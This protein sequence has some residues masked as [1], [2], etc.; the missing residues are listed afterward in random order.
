MSG[1]FR[2]CSDD[3]QR[4][5]KHFVILLSGYV[6]RNIKRS[7]DFSLVYWTRRT[8]ISVDCSVIGSGL[9]KTRKINLKHGRQFNKYTHNVGRFQN[10]DEFTCLF[11][12]GVGRK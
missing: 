11:K 10:S 5:F 1:D 7:L 12:V 8:V 6:S 4:R 9:L 3:L 2:G